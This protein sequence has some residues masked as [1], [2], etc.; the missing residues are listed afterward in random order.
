MAKPS[1]AVLLITRGT[2]NCIL[3][4]PDILGYH[5][6]FYLRRYDKSDALIGS[7]IRDADVHQHGINILWIQTAA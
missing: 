2:D 7:R 1:Y 6:L 3:Y 4:L 5:T